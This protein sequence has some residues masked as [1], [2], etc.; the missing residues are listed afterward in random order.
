VA[1]SRRAEVQPPCVATT[2]DKRI[3]VFQ[4]QS[5]TTIVFHC[6]PELSDTR[7]I[8]RLNSFS[9]LITK[10]RIILETLL[11]TI[12]ESTGYQRWAD[13]YFTTQTQFWIFETDFIL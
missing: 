5:R 3:Y 7:W 4:I 1:I 11:S 6:I 13:W 10:Y 9:V 12:E 8:S 2:R